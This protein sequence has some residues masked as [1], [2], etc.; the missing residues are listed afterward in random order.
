MKNIFANADKYTRLEYIIYLIAILI[1]VI[2][3]FV[4]MLYEYV[5]NE[6]IQQYNWSI[7][8]RTVC[9]TIPCLL[10]F[11]LNDQIL[12]PYLFMRGYRVLYFSVIPIILILVWCLSEPP[13]V[14][15]PMPSTFPQGRNEIHNP[16]DAGLRPHDSTTITLGI[17]QP[18][19]Q[20]GPNHNNKEF[21]PMHQHFP[22]MPNFFAI[23]NEL[24]IIGIILGNFALK[25]YM[26]TLR[27]ADRLEQVKMQQV[28]SELK[29][30]KYQI[31]PHFLMNTLNNL[32]ALID[33]DTER[34]TEVVQQLSKM[35]RYMLYESD[36][37][38]VPVRKE[39]EFMQHFIDLM[40]IR[41]P[42]DVKISASFPSVDDTIRI[43]SL[44]FI[45]FVENAFKYGIS[46]EKESVIDI[47]IKIESQ[48]LHFYCMNTI[49]QQRKDGD[50]GGI[51]LQN[52]RKRLDLLYPQ[53]Y[54]LNIADIDDRYV[55]SLSIPYNIV[56]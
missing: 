12:L 32:Q 25:L 28:T 19:Y 23:M 2:S 30:L 33:I 27:N 5:T 44:L 1:N 7:P 41:Y 54:T 10:I 47:S 20:F 15:P 26:H 51:G 48:Q 42:D 4:M 9:Y 16:M 40:K 21:R 55:V 24:I 6:Y 43:P 37:A 11:L 35:M 3:P 29:S 39:I 8:L 34:A 53:N 38:M 22:K 56:L 50:I 13:R 52:V 31:N 49:N 45:S 18:H 17:P 36:K 14:M 46:Y